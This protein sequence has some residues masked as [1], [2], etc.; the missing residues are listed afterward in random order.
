MK[1]NPK[2]NK[3]VANAAHEMR[4]ALV[5]Q[6]V[7]LLKLIGAKN[8]EAVLFGN[9]LIMYSRKKNGLTETIL[10]DR[11]C[12]CEV[13]DTNVFYMIEHDGKFTSSHFMSL[14]NMETVYEE[15]YKVVRKH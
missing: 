14:S 11:I 1:I 8:G 3:A 12:Y 6:T 2:H 15:V 13:H 5:E 7:A 10:A 4:K 9:L